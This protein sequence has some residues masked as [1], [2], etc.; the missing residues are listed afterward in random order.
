MPMN[1]LLIEQYSQII[2]DLIKYIDDI[3]WETIVNI[4]ADSYTFD[5][6][7]YPNNFFNE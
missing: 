5:A 2:Q 6:S 4:E 1:I 7:I 3:Y